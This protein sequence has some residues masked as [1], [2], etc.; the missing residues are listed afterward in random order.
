VGRGVGS[1]VPPWAGPFLRSQRMAIAATLDEHDRPWPSLLAGPP[2]FIQVADERLL[3]LAT[4][5]VAGDR[6]AANLAARP[7]LAL[8]IIDLAACRRLRVNGRGL[9]SPD[10]SVDGIFLLADE[11]YGNCP[12]YIEPRR[13]VGESAEPPGLPRRST[14][15]GASAR[16]L[17]AEADT[18]FIATWHPKAGADASHRGGPK[19]FVRVRD[20]RTLEFPDY[21]GNN[22][23]N[24]LGNLFGH[25]AAGLLF[26]DFARGD[27]LQVGGRARILWDPE[28][29]VRVEVDTVIEIPGGSPLRFV[30]LTAEPP[31]AVTP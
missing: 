15:L 9:V 2:G 6:L 22:M 25:P 13:V 23:F 3:R 26:V 8:L 24:T 30:T 17:V 31:S 4:T 5:P 12:K 27:L 11:V 21:P 14:S 29:A 28:T 16:A 1:V 10:G 18:F 20:D 7:E 19:G